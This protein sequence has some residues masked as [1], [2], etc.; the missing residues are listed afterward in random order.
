MPRKAN[1]SVVGVIDTQAARVGTRR[2]RRGA[3]GYKRTGTAFNVNYKL[4]GTC[5]EA[6]RGVSAQVPRSTAAGAAGGAG[7]QQATEARGNFQ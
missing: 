5:Q 4:P 1:R 2:R 7:P 3:R 6:R